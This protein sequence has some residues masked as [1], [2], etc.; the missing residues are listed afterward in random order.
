MLNYRKEGMAATV[1]YECTLV[2]ESLCKGFVY[3]IQ[4]RDLCGMLESY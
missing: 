4:F 1:L 3:T 2:L